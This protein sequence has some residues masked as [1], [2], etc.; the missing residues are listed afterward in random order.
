MLHVERIDQNLSKLQ[1]I[2][3]RDL[4]LGP[5]DGEYLKDRAETMAKLSAL[6]ILNSQ[7][8]AGLKLLEMSLRVK[9]LEIVNHGIKSVNDNLPA[10]ENGLVKITDKTV[11]AI[12]FVGSRV[13][14]KE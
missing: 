6:M 3:K 10:F 2:A 8:G 1:G 13:H 5:L 12:N 9:A 14:H 4:E 7:F 11:S